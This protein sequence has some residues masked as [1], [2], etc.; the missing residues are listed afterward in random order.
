[1]Y[2]LSAFFCI[3]QYVQRLIIKCRAFSRFNSKKN[4]I[5]PILVMKVHYALH[6]LYHRSLDYT[7]PIFLL[8][9][10]QSKKRLKLVDG[11]KDSNSEINSS[12]L[13]STCVSSD[14]V[15][16]AMSHFDC[17]VCLHRLSRVSR[18]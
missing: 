10:L 2:L 5:L 14:G 15:G 13:G 1:M 8:V 17:G 9:G 16:P 4:H 7:F 6:Y 11:K 3:M 18:N 12:Y